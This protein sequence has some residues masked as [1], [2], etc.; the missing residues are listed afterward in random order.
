MFDLMIISWESEYYYEYIYSCN[1][2]LYDTFCAHASEISISKT[3]HRSKCAVK[4][5]VYPSTMKNLKEFLNLLFCIK[6]LFNVWMDG[7]LCSQLLPLA[8]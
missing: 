7:I 3:N 1:S 8:D 2:H 4:N 5:K 6:L